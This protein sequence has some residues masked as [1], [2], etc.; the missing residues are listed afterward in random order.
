MGLF[1]FFRRSRRQRI[2]RQ[3]PIAD[4]AWQWVV[5]EHP[6]L[7]RLAETDRARLRELTTIFLAEKR[8]R[9][10][11][12]FAL[13]PHMIL[14][15]A[16][17]AVLPVLALGLDWL[18]GIKTIYLTAEAFADRRKSWDGLVMTEYDDVLSGEVTEFRSILLS[19]KDV[20]AS[21]WGEGYNVVIH[22]IAHILDDTNLAMDGCPHLDLLDPARWQLVFTA[23]YQ[24]LKRRLYGDPPLD[25]YAA[26]DP[27]E[28]FAVACEEFFERPRRL[29]RNY[30]EV[31][32][33]LVSF[34]GWDPSRFE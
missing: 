32:E 1:D 17:Q 29:R 5:E 33:Q 15:V 23:A 4:E 28:F 24:D 14:S 27:S 21:G 25:P 16:V 30:P 18:A 34:F 6:I 22:E 7:R 10:L 26:E 3:R 2:L 31:Y 9:G 12:G 8:F 19:W 11:R 13:E 20:E